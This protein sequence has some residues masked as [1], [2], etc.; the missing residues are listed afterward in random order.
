M[1]TLQSTAGLFVALVLTA[2]LVPL[3][4]AQTLQ[5]G[6]PIIDR[7]GFP[8]GYQANYKLLYTFD[9]FQNRQIRI[10]YGNEIA[11]SVKPGQ[12][13]PYGS[14]IVGEFWPALR[15]AQGEPVLDANARFIKDSQ[16]TVFVMRKEAGFGTSYK[17]IRNGEWEYVSYRPDG[18]YATRPE[19]TT[20]CATCHLQAG[21]QRDWV[22]RANLFLFGGSGAA[23]DGVLK[24][25]RF[26]PGTLRAK[27][28]VPVTIY[29]DD[30][31]DFHDIVADNGSF[32]SGRLDGGASFTFT[33][34]EP[35]TYA[36]HCT[37]HSRMK[38]T[39]VVEP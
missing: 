36:V 4:C 1:K 14:I 3:G 37:R 30:D 12:P 27:A 5:I 17:D 24:F 39:V 29:N 38:G 16:P 33:F 8:V 11:A 2:F 15:D 13:F 23:A 32:D 22:F 10:A 28:G 19:G 34:K 35:G 9:H 25:Y 21:P 7:I 31:T 6:A 20:S 18:T 26:V